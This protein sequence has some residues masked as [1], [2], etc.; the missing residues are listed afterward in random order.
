[1]RLCQ[2]QVGYIQI[3]SWQTCD[4]V[5]TCLFIPMLSATFLSKEFTAK[6]GMTGMQGSW[7]QHL[8]TQEVQRL[9]KH[10]TRSR[11]DVRGTMLQRISGRRKQPQNRKGMEKKTRKDRRR[12]SWPEG[13]GGVRRN[14]WFSK[15]APAVSVELRHPHLL[16]L[17]NV[18][19]SE[20]V[21]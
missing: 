9:L 21:T 8:F 19:L 13:N 15:R 4:F 3:R 17:M 6:V 16:L 1:M 5:T 2:K 14:I 11:D 10:L 20:G 18:F 7:G 12:S